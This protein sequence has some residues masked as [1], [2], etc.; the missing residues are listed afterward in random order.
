M[1]FSKSTSRGLTKTGWVCESTKPGRTTLPEQSISVTLLRFFLSQGSRSASFVVPT[2]TTFPPQHKTA[3]SSMMPSSF[4]SE[5]RRGPGLPEADRSVRSWPILARNSGGW[6][7]WAG[8]RAEVTLKQF[9]SRR[10]KIARGRPIGCVPEYPASYMLR[11]S[12]SWTWAW[13]RI[14]F[15]TGDRVNGRWFLAATTSHPSALSPRPS[16]QTPSLRRNPHPR[17]G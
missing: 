6:I 12:R 8:F 1:R 16:S 4:R 2:E 13:I 9:S 14:R 17:G 7:F 15:L 3:P 5:P 11:H 10:D